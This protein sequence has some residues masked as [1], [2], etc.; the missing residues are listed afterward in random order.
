MIS[1]LPKRTPLLKA[2]SNP[3]AR[4]PSS[5]HAR[6]ARTDAP[7]VP[8]ER[9]TGRAGAMDPGV[10]GWMAEDGEGWLR[11]RLAVF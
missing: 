10:H 5:P 4:A 11:S 7:P 2:R 6:S 1:K 8:G 3:V 9:L